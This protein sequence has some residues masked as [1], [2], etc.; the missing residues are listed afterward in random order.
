MRHTT[1]HLRRRQLDKQLTSLLPLAHSL[2]QRKGWIREVRDALGM[3]AEQL[4]GRAGV[5]QP[6]VAK[7]ERSEVA[8]TIALQ[9]LQKMADALDC[10]LVYAFVPLESLEATLTRQARHQAALQIGR[11]EHTMR[12][13]AQGRDREETDRAQQELAQEMIQTL[14]RDL[15]EAEG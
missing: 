8:G 13:E 5:S 7:L 15:W 1:A 2:R 14:S 11:V 4:A 3:T 6:T 10:T 9:S 12:L